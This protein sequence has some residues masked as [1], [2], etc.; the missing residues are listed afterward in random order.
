MGMFRTA[1]SETRESADRTTPPVSDFAEQAARAGLILPKPKKQNPF[2]VALIVV[3]IVI[4]SLGI[5]RVTGWLN[6]ATPA[7]TPFNCNGASIRVW[8]GVSDTPALLPRLM[9]S[10][11]S[12]F[13][14][15]T[16]GCGHVAV[17]FN[18]SAENSTL[19]ALSAR[20]VDFSV[21]SEYPTPMELA[22][23]PA[24]TLVVPVTLGG[25]GIVVN[26]PGVSHSVNLTSAALAGIYLGTIKSWSDPAIARDNPGIVW[27]ANATI[28][29]FFLSGSSAL[30]DALSTFLAETNATWSSTMGVAP[31]VTWPAGTGLATDSAMVQN[32][33]S[34][35]GAIGYLE[36]G[37][38]IGR[39]LTVAQVE[40]ANGTFLLP[41]A[42]SVSTAVESALQ[43]LPS[44]E[45][46]A[47]S[48]GSWANVSVINAP[49]SGSYPI[50]VFSYLTVYGDLGRAYGT[51]LNGL[52]ARIASILLWWIVTSGQSIAAAGGLIPLPNAVTQYCLIGLGE[53][54]YDGIRLYATPNGEGGEGGGNETGEF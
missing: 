20:G 25:L 37:T 32:L 1:D 39:G 34:T 16:A 7:Q 9:A 47:V 6:P 54:S 24:Q 31:P 26:L 35:P 10:M 29:P 51:A 42:Q 52:S 13:A 44:T 18:A 45:R 14:N 53:L 48:N 15:S 46:N 12:E 4:A 17:D 43:S 22:A 30:T 2:L 40:N 19:A 3:V 27:P 11:G 33:S 50:P 21:L 8:A 28:H 23:L 36:Q 41:N 49:G 38:S 5:G